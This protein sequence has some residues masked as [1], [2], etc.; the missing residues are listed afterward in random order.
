MAVSKI[1]STIAAQNTTSAFTIAWPQPTAPGSRLLAFIY[2]RMNIDDDFTLTPP[3][4]WTSVGRYERDS[5]VSVE[6]FT[7]S[8]ASRSGNE[9]F[10][11]AHGGDTVGVLAEYSAADIV[12]NNGGSGGFGATPTAGPV[13]AAAGDMV[14]GAIASPNADAQTGI[15]G[16]F[17]T[18]HYAGT[19]NASNS[20][21]IQG[22]LYGIDSATAGV[23]QATVALAQGRSYSG[24]SFVLRE[25][26][27]A[28]RK[29][30]RSITA[31]DG[32]AFTRDP[33][34][35]PYPA[36]SFWNLPIA[37][38][39]T[40]KPLNMAA[41][42]TQGNQYIFRW[43]EEVI[44]GVAPGTLDLPEHTILHHTVGWTGQNRCDNATTDPLPASSGA[45]I[46]GDI[47]FP[48]SFNTV[49]Y[50]GSTPN[51][52]S[53]HLRRRGG[54]VVLLECQPT[55]FCGGTK[56]VSQWTN[57]KWIGDSIMT[58]GDSTKGGSH[59]GSG[60][61]AL[62]GTIRLHE[63]RPGGRIPHATKIVLDTG[64]VCYDHSTQAACWTWPA[65]RADSGAVTNY[66]NNISTAIPPEARMGMLLT[67][68]AGFDTEA[69][70]T[71]PARILARSIKEYGTYLCDGDN[72]LDV[73][74]FAVE[75]SESGRFIDQFHTDFGIKGFH[76][77]AQ[78]GTASTLQQQFW[79]DMYS[80]YTAFQIVTN[81]TI[82]TPG[83]GTIGAP[84][85]TAMAGPLGTAP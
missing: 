66:G 70:Q 12:N 68:T 7:V 41:V 31:V 9:V 54:D 19:T 37:D 35:Q 39:A 74:M 13:T 67:L 30:H 23:H 44:T 16:G 27:V 26:A 34:L 57:P 14:L 79:A 36:T 65:D 53:A 20:A 21:R 62:G 59:G 33:L 50:L 81:N 42:G 15:G 47:P 49:N 28:K 85:R 82:S 72:G 46:D 3:A 38:G 83:G 56:A 75:W 6:V 78:D 2:Q 60:L 29:I 71:E 73:A 76:R 84:R 45:P 4:G 52:A 1:Q 64:R 51:H 10:A 43:E 25:P 40:L 17:S 22:G 55:H 61:S 24:V 5:Q 69:L 8:G 48:L 11:S 32:E 63:W 18:V 58:G 77:P 80:I